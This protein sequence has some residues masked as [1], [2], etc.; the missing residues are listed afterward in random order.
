M[1][2]YLLDTNHV[3]A[4]L[5]GDNGLRERV[6]RAVA[7]GDSFSVATTVMGE[8]YLRALRSRRREENLQA[9]EAFLRTVDVWAFDDVAAWEYGNIL[10]ASR[11]AGR[12]LP[13]ADAHIAAVCLARG[14]TLLSADD[15][16]RY[17]EGLVV[18]DWLVS[19]QA[20]NQYA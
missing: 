18:E 12:P 6:R 4:L 3:D 20:G 15:H 11:T 8:L 19:H 13:Q 14:L 17:V 9:T 7:Q 10:L 1:A 5:R 16:F 2:D